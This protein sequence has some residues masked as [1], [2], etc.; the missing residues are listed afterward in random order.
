MATIKRKASGKIITK[1]GKVSCGCCGCPYPFDF[2]T[3]L[4]ASREQIN[5]GDNSYWPQ[6][7]MVS[8]WTQI[9]NIDEEPVYQGTPPENA[10]SMIR[11][12]LNYRRDISKPPR[13]GNGNGSCA[14]FVCAN[15][16]YNSET[17]TSSKTLTPYGGPTTTDRDLTELIIQ[18]VPSNIWQQTRYLLFKIEFY[19]WWYAFLSSGRPNPPRGGIW[20]NHWQGSDTKFTIKYATFTIIEQ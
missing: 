10:I 15:V 13:I 3:L 18:Y 6:D 12:Q 11:D 17:G 1:N 4:R 2:F 9:A 19:A 16:F 20:Y 8:A 7:V 14:R 5:L